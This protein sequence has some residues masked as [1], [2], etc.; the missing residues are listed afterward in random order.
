MCEKVGD[1]LGHCIRACMLHSGLPSQFWGAAIIMAADVYNITTHRAF[2]DQDTPY[3]KQFGYHTQMDH[4]L[5]FGCC[6]TVFR[7]KELVFHRKLAPWGLACVYV[8]TG[9][10]FGRKYFLVYSPG[11][12]KVYAM[13]DCQFDKTYF[14]YW[15]A[16]TKCLVESAR[17]FDGSI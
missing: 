11:E 9:M 15:H 14:P 1:T 6:C 17:N 16:C 4:F 7:G 13:V 3:H 10:S 12:H 8:G 2:D 5:P